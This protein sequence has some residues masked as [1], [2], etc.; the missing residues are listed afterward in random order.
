MIGKPQWFK[1]RKYG[2]WGVTPASWQGWTYIAIF[3]GIVMTVQSLPINEQLRSI[4]ATAILI[5]LV[6]DVIDIMF[7]I[8]KDERE[9]LHEAISERNAS[10]TMVFSLTGIFIY[11]SVLSVINGSHDIDLIF[12]V[13]I[14]LGVATKGIT[15]L[16]LDK[17]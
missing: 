1:T 6:V 15:N 17:R 8:K 5:L 12:L 14:I 3:I 10:W 9:I 16:Y 13:P 4:L 11:K 7:R 2:G